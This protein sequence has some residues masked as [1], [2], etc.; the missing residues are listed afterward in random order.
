LILLVGNITLTEQKL[1]SRIKTEISKLKKDKKIYIIHNLKDFTTDE[2]VND[3][4]EN[5]LK[6]LY[7]IE[8]N[9]NIYQNLG[10]D[11]E[12]ENKFFDKYKN[13]SCCKGYVYK[14]NGEACK[15]LGQCYCKMS[16]DCENEDKHY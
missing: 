5:T 7:K 11:G 16:D 15:S 6:K 1:L 8:I 9:E 3:Y 4:I 14:C 13:C 2:Q 12:D 10:D